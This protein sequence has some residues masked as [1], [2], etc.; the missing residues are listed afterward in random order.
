MKIHSRLLEKGADVEE[1]KRVAAHATIFHATASIGVPMARRGGTRGA[2]HGSAGL[3]RRHCFKF[4]AT[5]CMERV[6]PFVCTGYRTTPIV[7]RILPDT[8]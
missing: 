4:L 5:T 7:Y 3:T 8:L 2:A 1:M 6:N